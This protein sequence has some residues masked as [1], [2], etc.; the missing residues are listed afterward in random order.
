MNAMKLRRAL[1]PFAMLLVFAGTG[2]ALAD[3]T[4]FKVPLTG[5]ECV[6]AVETNGS[7]TADLTYDPATRVLTWN[8][9]YS[10]LSSPTTMPRASG[11]ARSASRIPAS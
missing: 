2:V 1:V 4:S 7:G 8:I 9:S 6:P 5:A 3:S 11:A 10:G